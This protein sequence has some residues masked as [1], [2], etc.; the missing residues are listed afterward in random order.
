MMPRMRNLLVA[1]AMAASSAAAQ[2]PPTYSCDS[3][4]SRALD[5]WLGEWELTSR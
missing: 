1:A 3:P 5:F 2:A 4:E